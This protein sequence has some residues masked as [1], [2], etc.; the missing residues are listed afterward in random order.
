MP[1]E[2]STAETKRLA[3]H[4]DWQQQTPDSEPHRS[5]DRKGLE[6]RSYDGNK[7][8]PEPSAAVEA[9]PATTTATSRY[10][11]PSAAETKESPGDYAVNEPMQAPA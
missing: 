5:R 2:P 10:P 7:P 9:E 1:E 4:S 3:R 11:E 8:T 6:Q